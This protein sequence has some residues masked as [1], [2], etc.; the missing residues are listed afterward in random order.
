[1]GR[2]TGRTAV[3]TG[4]S[5][6]IGRAIAQRLAADGAEIAVHY[7]SGESAAK[8]T[9]AGI[10]KAGGRAFAVR[11]ELGTAGDVDTLVTA[12]ERGLAG[13]PLD[14]LV[15]N[16]AALPAGP[17]E[18]DTPEQFDRLFAVNVKAPYFLIQRALPLLRDGGRIITLT[19]VAAR[20][21]LPGQTS[22]AMGKGALETMTLTLASALGTRGITVNAVAPG[23]TK[24]DVNVPV[25]EA[26]GVEELITGQTALDRLGRAEDVADAVAFLASDDGR[27]ITGQILDASG[28]L[29][30]GA[31]G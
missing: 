15:N 30:L 17:I 22:F 19:S 1:M 26:P 25:F 18:T 12:V 7:G 10:E 16:A 4:A 27:W 6:G 2:L 9:V 28:G 31:R 21:A 14:I 20:M 23:A 5:R 11:A 13:R 3:V 24:T 8:E 29:H